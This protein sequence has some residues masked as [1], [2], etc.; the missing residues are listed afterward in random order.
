MD[1]DTSQQPQQLPAAQPDGYGQS[2]QQ[3][4]GQPN[5]QPAQQE[6]GQL[7]GQAFQSGGCNQAGQQG[8]GQAYGQSTQQGYQ[9]G[10]YGR[11]AQQP[12]QP[13]QTEVIGYGGTY[14]M[15]ETDRTLRLVAFVFMVVSTVSVCWALIPLAW[16]IPMTVVAWGI[17]KG[18]RPNTVAFG[19]CTLIF[20]SL[21]AGI[22]LLVSNK[23][24]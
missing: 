10:G 12:Y 21:V 2:G 15:T 13:Y 18:T 8:A 4:A 6:P 16:M 20:V 17:Y 24:R 1:D 5:G 23:D 19:V 3:T 22:L 11:P 14:P 9:P 7:Y